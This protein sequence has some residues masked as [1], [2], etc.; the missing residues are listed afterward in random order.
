MNA[1]LALSQDRFV[2]RETDGAASVFTRLQPVSKPAGTM[3]GWVERLWAAG[4][5]VSVA[6][7]GFLAWR[8][9]RS[10]SSTPARQR[11]YPCLKETSWAAL[12][13]TV[14]R[15]LADIEDAQWMPWVALGYDREDAFVFLQEDELQEHGRSAAALEA[16]ALANLRDREASWQMAE[17]GLKGGVRLQMVT[18]ADDFFAAERILEPESILEAQRRLGASELLAAVP[19][20]GLLALVDADLGPEAIAW[21]VVMVAEEHFGGQSRRSRRWSS[22]WPVGEIAACWSRVAASRRAGF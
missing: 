5:V 18:C 11:I 14:R 1:I 17:V 19:R 9:L 15:P 4:V 21:F 7:L 12:G 2:L 10:R 8:L 13:P 20:R 16:E 3:P 6:A 22:G